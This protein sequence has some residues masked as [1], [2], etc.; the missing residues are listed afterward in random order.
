M[1]RVL[2]R[3]TVPVPLAGFGLELIEAQAERC[4]RSVAAF[5][6]RAAE[7]YTAEPH[8]DRPSHVVP[9]FLKESGPRVGQNRVDVELSPELWSALER[10]AEAQGVPIELIV[11]HAAM[12]LAAELAA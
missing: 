6:E 10:D 2:R 8:P 4:G 9:R 12:W 5:M 7:R 11:R 1:R 3:A